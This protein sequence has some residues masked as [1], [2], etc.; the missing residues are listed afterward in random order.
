MAEEALK[1]IS[2]G[3]D[4]NRRS[5]RS[6]R[7]SLRSSRL[8]SRLSERRLTPCAT[9][10][11]VPTVAAVR[12]TGLG[13]I[14]PCR[15]MRALA[16]ACQDSP[17][18]LRRHGYAFNEIRPRIHTFWVRPTAGVLHMFMGMAAGAA[19][20]GGFAMTRQT[21]QRHRARVVASWSRV[22]GIAGIG[23]PVR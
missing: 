2:L 18:W 4:Q 19:A 14:T 5:L 21:T 23:Y 12:A 22:S 9:T 16:K 17:S 8:S 7:R 11:T 6:S 10:A 20:Q 15:P 3:L 13:L 1:I